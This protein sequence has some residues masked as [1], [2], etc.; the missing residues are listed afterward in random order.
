MFFNCIL[1]INKRITIR[2]AIRL[3]IIIGIT[4]RYLLESDRLCSYTATVH[5]VE[6]DFLL[7]GFADIIN[8]IGE[9]KRYLR[10]NI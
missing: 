10:I 4:T 3:K 1:Y 7:A 5:R 2:D 6:E 9:Q 8:Q